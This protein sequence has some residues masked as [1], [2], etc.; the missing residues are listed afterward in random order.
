MENSERKIIA[1]EQ[2]ELMEKRPYHFTMNRRSFFEVLGSGIAITFSFTNAIGKTLTD[3]VPEDQVAAWI[4]VGEKGNVTIYSGKAEVGQNIRTSLAQ[5]V[6]EELPVPLDK[7]DMVLGDTELTPYDRG[8]FGSRSIPYMGPQ[9]RKAAASAREL[10]IDM[11]A[12]QWKVDRSTLFMEEGVVKNRSTKQSMEIG[13]LTKGQKLLKPIND[14]VEVTP[15]KDWK[16]A[17]TSVKKVRGESFVTGKHKYVSDMNLPGMLHGKILRAP[18]Y[19]ATLI[20]A[21]VSAA[22]K[23]AWC[24]RCERRRFRW[25]SCSAC[26]HGG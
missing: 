25:S 20:S 15:P 18:A 24:Y 9:L 16:I 3:G 14:K 1:P 26:K 8:T 7:I 22:Q 21:D 19:G 11:A 13:E 12:T 2:Y 23:Y 17:G 5:I 6:A 10:L 4:H